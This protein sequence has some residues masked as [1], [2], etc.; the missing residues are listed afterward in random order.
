MALGTALWR[1]NRSGFPQHHH[2]HCR[3]LSEPIPGAGVGL[4]GDL[5]W[6]DVGARGQD[7]PWPTD[8]LS[9]PLGLRH[10]PAAAPRQPLAKLPGNSA[11]LGAPRRHRRSPRRDRNCRRKLAADPASAGSHSLRRRQLSL[12]QQ[13]ATATA[14]CE[15]RDPSGQLCGDCWQQRLRQE[16]HAQAADQAV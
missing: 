14:E 3:R 16:H 5:V 1:P 13:W 11:L 8:R 7:D 9:H 12:W 6:S 2:Q 4:G 15:F 10:Q